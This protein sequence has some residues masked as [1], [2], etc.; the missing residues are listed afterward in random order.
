MCV[1]ACACAC[2]TYLCNGEHFD[3]IVA[4]EVSETS[5]MTGRTTT[6][7]LLHRPHSLNLTPLPL[8]PPAPSPHADS[9]TKFESQFRTNYN[10]P[11]TRHPNTLIFIPHSQSHP[12]SQ[13]TLQITLSFIIS[14]LTHHESPPLSNPLYH[15][16]PP[17]SQFTT[18]ITPLTF[19]RGLCTAVSWPGLGCP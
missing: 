9:T 19:G 8:I 6:P 15:N 13:F 12:L 10:P 2:Y 4:V 1:C 18:S 11:T 16:S 7:P 17:V 5:C 3:G 14:P